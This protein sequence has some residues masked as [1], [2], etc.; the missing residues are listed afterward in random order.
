MRLLLIC[1]RYLNAI[2]AS[3]NIVRGVVKQLV[4]EGFF[5]DVL[6]EDKKGTIVSNGAVNIFCI[7]G[8]FWENKSQELK[9]KHPL[10]YRFALFVRK[11]F[12]VFRIKSYPNVEPSLSKRM[13]AFYKTKLFK[14]KYDCIVSFFRPFF[15]LDVGMWIKK[16]NANTFFVPVIFDLIE[17]KDRPSF[18]PKL[19]F[20]RKTD[21]AFRRLFSF[22]SKVLIPIY[23]KDSKPFYFLD[24]S[25]IE[26]YNFPTFDLSTNY[27]SGGKR[28]FFGNGLIRFL[29]AGTLS[30]SF[31]SPK[32]LLETLDNLAVSIGNK[33]F[34]L[35]LFVEGD[36][37]EIINSFTPT[38]NF[39]I[40]KRG[41]VPKEEL[42]IAKNDADFLVNITNE[43][44]AI[45][46]SKVFELLSTGKPLINIVSNGDDGSLAY[47]NRY[48]LHVNV[49]SLE[50]IDPLASFIIQNMGK[51]IIKEEL[52]GLYEE[53]TMKFFVNQLTS[54]SKRVK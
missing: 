41:F 18:M 3:T 9:K 22:S 7:K 31:R 13:F 52:E 27:L 51:T 5:V 44:K 43:Y 17:P 4:D 49:S 2:D 1:Q 25:K 20:E 16:L 34:Q 8:S 23:Q 30:R 19:L 47:M 32:K 50:D 15:S 46:P 42:A 11:I 10:S 35:L 12:L 37:D 33:R 21:Q 6:C 38:K 45:V 36:C 48:P 26:Y 39:E 54:F 14:N 40:I 29:Y 53:C 28:G 24:A